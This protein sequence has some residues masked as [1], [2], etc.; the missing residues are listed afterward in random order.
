MKGLRRVAIAAAALAL[1]GTFLAPTVAVAHGLVGRADLPIPEWLFGWAAAVVMVVSFVA[2]STLWQE[3]K[4]EEDSGFRPAPDWL[5]FTL[6]N[7][8]TEVAAGGT[9]TFSFDG[10][11]DGRFEVE[12]ESR[13]EQIAQ[14]E[15]DP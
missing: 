15:V 8:A 5:S 11:I 12:L 3:P 4:L 7:P 1:L 2:L 14:L 10:D 13:G 6:I 9:A